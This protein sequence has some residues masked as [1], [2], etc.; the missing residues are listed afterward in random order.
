M[1]S[2]A[3]LLLLV[4]SPDGPLLP[5]FRRARADELAQGSASPL[6]LAPVPRLRRAAWR[7]GVDMRPRVPAS[8]FYWLLEGAS[9]LLDA[10]RGGL[11]AAALAANQLS[12]IKP[13]RP[14]QKNYS[15]LVEFVQRWA[16][17]LAPGTGVHSD[18]ACCSSTFSY[19]PSARQI[20][21]DGHLLCHGRAALRRDPL[22]GRRRGAGS[23]GRPGTRRPQR[24]TQA[25]LQA[26][27]RPASAGELARATCE[28]A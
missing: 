3:G 1:H 7:L 15:D 10:Q 6:L 4:L 27:P 20:S 12:F 21:R 14:R 5:A 26:G 24:R 17:W 22:I 9:R 25:A 19:T 16:E 18:A 11:C 2:A 8:S 13:S 23:H 28:R